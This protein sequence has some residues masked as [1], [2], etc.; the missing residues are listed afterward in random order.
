MVIDMHAHLGSSEVYPDAFI[1]AMLGG[2]SKKLQGGMALKIAKR[3]LSDS[4]GNRLLADMDKAG[5]E[6]TALLIID[7]GV[8][9]Q[10]SDSSLELSYEVH[11]HVMQSAPD[12]FVVFGGIDARRGQNALE[13]FRQSVVDWGFAGLKLYPPM[14]F[15][16]D[17]SRLAPY[18]EICAERGL[19]VITHSGSSLP[20]LENDFGD[21]K[22]VIQ[23]AR[24]WPTISVVAAHAGTWLSKPDYRAVAELPN[25]WV[26]ISGFQVLRQLGNE[27]IIENLK[28]IFEPEFNSRVLFGSD[29]PVFHSSQTLE[30]DVNLIRQVSE[31]VAAGKNEKLEN[32]LKRNALRLLGTAKTKQ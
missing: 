23:L 31:T 13:L 28:T 19:P 7:F 20:S 9:F 5:I 14:G 15:S 30:Q 22:W 8:Q 2:G 16:P 26:D 1:G 11:R 27:L 12:R 18:L 24:R 4:H 3:W 17:D 21:P 29:Y 25:I 6:K 10:Q 32:I